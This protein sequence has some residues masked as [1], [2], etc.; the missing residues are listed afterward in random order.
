MVRAL[1][2]WWKYIQLLQAYSF[3]FKLF[4]VYNDLLEFLS[5]FVRT[6]AML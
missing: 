4:E 5:V 6:H 2:E 3:D 1:K